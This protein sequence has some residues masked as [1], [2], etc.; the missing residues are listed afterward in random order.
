[1]KN[2]PFLSRSPLLALGLLMFFC[3]SHALAWGGAQ[4]VYINRYA[5]YN[6]P[7]EMTG[8]RAFARPMAFPGIYPDLWKSHDRAETPRHYFEPDRLPGEFDMYSIPRDQ[9][10]GLASVYL[11]KEELGIA[12]W[13]ILELLQQMSEAMRTNDWM[14]AAR[15]GATMGHYVGDLHMP[16]HC[17]RNYNGQET[18]QYGVHTRME[19]DMTKAFFRKENMRVKRGKYLE[20]PFHSVLTWVDESVQQIPLIL[21]SDIIAKRTAGGRTD[22]EAYYLKFWELMEEAIMGRISD[23]ASNLASLW[24]TAWV[25]AGK[26]AIP[27]PFDE[28]P[29]TSLFTGIGIDAADTDSTPLPPNR[30][31]KKYDLIVWCAMGGMAALIVA[32]SLFRS[33]RRKKTGK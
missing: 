19:I 20:D 23:A 15:C 33:I 32:S 4:H 28:L 29:D 18:G 14:W 9:T 30:Q 2:I 26:P 13:V 6:V 24:Y 22:N 8:W 17:T 5:G 12:P 3:A 1:M 31:K 27:A 25:D 7:P 21:N 10:D 11:T 16:L